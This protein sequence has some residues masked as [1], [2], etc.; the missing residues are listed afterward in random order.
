MYQDDEV[1][2]FMDL[3]PVTRGHV[4]VIPRDHQVGLL[5]LS[6]AIGERLWGIGQTLADALRS[7]RIPCEGI[8]L[9]VCDGE[10]AYQSSSSA[11]R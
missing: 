6:P 3:F 1:V 10:V 7:S 8:N 2:A 11:P 9:L 4:L 5:D